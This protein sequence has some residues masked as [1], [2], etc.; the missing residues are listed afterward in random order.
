MYTKN[1]N[2]ITMNSST[3]Y[4]NI[5]K[6]YTDVLIVLIVL[7]LNEMLAH[8][9]IEQNQA[10]GQ[11]IRREGLCQ[12]NQSRGYWSF[13]SNQNRNSMSF[14]SIQSR[15]SMPFRSNQSRGSKPFRYNQSR[16]TVPFPSNQSKGSM[17]FRSNHSRGSVP[18]QSSDAVGHF[19]LIQ[20][21]NGGTRGLCISSASTPTPEGREEG[22]L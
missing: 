18:F 4:N 2:P 8:N 17:S 13:R 14:R 11:L 6:V 21:S 16:D 1:L 19:V 9:K 7:L 10:V 20:Y 22:N 5:A 3:S 12:S 15:G